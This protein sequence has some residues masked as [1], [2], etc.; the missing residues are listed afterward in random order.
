MCVQVERSL[1]LALKNKMNDVVA[2]RDRIIGII[3]YIISNIIYSCVS[4]VLLH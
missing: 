3:P 2:E 4:L 1:D